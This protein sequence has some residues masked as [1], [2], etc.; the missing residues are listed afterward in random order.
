MA[1]S[2]ASHHPP[3]PPLQQPSNGKDQPLNEVALAAMRAAAA[4]GAAPNGAHVPPAGRG[5]SKGKVRL[6]PGNAW[7]TVWHP[8]SC[9]PAAAAALKRH[10]RPAR[11]PCQV[12]LTE[13]D[14]LAL[15]AKLEDRSH[16]L[17]WP[18]K[19]S[20]IEIAWWAE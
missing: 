11:P 17:D 2:S 6:G 8:A 7:P 12:R 20:F 19:R 1:A 15:R 4:N 9:P 3:L 5:L 10:T 13:M 18:Q 16:F 14:M